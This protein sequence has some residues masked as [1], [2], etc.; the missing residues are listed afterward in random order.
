[1]EEIQPIT[2]NY[3]FYN[4]ERINELTNKSQE[5]INNYIKN[6]NKFTVGTKKKIAIINV[7]HAPSNRR[8][9][10]KFICYTFSINENRELYKSDTDY[11]YSTDYSKTDLENHK[12]N[13]IENI[14][15]T[16]K[17]SDKI[18]KILP[19]DKHYLY[20]R[21]KRI[22]DIVGK[23]TK[24][25]E[26]VVKKKMKPP[27]Q[28]KDVIVVFTRYAPRAS[29]STL[30]THFAVY[31]LLPS[32]ELKRG[33][34]DRTHSIAYTRAEIEHYGYKEWHIER[35]CEMIEGKQMEVRMK[36]ASDALDPIMVHE[37]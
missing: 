11:D 6:N 20:Y 14:I 3:V 35:F 30:T 27:K 23:S 18:N 32:L 5:E 8:F 7:I 4:N 24:D 29:G 2:I 22:P 17:E 31:H 13:N 26:E 9:M 36:N 37:L 12:Y 19:L 10:L 28:T 25:L 16:L 33:I 1:M 21:G 15:L 34:L